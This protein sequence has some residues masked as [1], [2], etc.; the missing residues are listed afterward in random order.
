M[1]FASTHSVCSPPWRG[2]P[3]IES[4]LGRAGEVRGSAEGDLP[5]WIE[6]EQVGM[7]GGGSARRPPQSSSHSCSW[8]CLPI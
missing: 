3:P 6:G 2:H 4:Y 8:P 7:C 1:K 5:S